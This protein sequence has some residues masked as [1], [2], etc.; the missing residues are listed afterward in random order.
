MGVLAKAT[1]SA[2]SALLALPL[3][4]A[5]AVI[6][7][8]D[9]FLPDLGDAAAA[10]STHA[11]ADI[12]ARMLPLYQRAAA[13]CP[14]LPWTIL[15]AIGKIETDHGRAPSMVSR[16]G[17]VGPMQFLPTTFAAY[18]R[19][20]PRGG[21]KPPTPWDPVD[22][23]FAASRLLCVNGAKHGTHLDRAIYAY[24]HSRTYVT[25]VTRTARTYAAHPPTTPAATTA[26]AFARHHLGTPYLWGGDGPTEGGFDCSGLTK[27]AYA[28]AG[29]A[30]PRTAQTQYDAG[31]RI[32]RRSPLLP[33]DLLFYG[34]TPHHIT[35]VALHTGNHHMIDAPRPGAVVREGPALLTTTY[36]GATRPSLHAHP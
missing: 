10:P 31:P 19:P 24:N 18:A 11:H 32:P 13:P 23:V 5:I 35:H 27:A 4:T 8:L 28:A 30:L 6:A 16:A 22:A 25:A 9:P 17:A 34:T 12:P 14:G 7:V 21:K 29:I 2:G 33:G 1:T 3:L 15:A 20:V 26:I 36:Q